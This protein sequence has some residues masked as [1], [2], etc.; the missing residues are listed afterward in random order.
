MGHKELKAMN[1]D[2]WRVPP[3]RRMAGPH[4]GLPIRVA[5]PKD[6]EPQ[7]TDNDTRA[8]TSNIDV[9]QVKNSPDEYSFNHHMQLFDFF[10]FKLREGNFVSSMTDEEKS[11]AQNYAAV[12]HS[13]LGGCGCTQDSRVRVAIESYK[14][15]VTS[16]EGAHKSLIEKVK[17]HLNAKTLI[18]LHQGKEIARF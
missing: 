15:M 17:E 14:T 4:I 5:P 10:S 12:C 8:V 6:V 13:T 11:I 7:G 18:F 1:D 2:P 3:P 16:T 9:S